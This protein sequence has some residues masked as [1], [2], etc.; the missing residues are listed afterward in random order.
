MKFERIKNWLKTASATEI[1]IL[2]TLIRLRKSSLKIEKA[3]NF[4]VG[5]PV[6]FVSQDGDI[7]TGK[8]TSIKYKYAYVTDARDQIWKISIMYL[9]KIP[10]TE[11]ED[12]SDV[13]E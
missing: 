6:S 5:D 1:Q 4:S 2:E 11:L 3:M 13:F 9:N 7:I 12:I 8:I 10:L